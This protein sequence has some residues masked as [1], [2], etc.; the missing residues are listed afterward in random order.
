MIQNSAMI[1]AVALF[2]CVAGACSPAHGRIV[3]S[4]PIELPDTVPLRDPARPAISPVGIGTA[5]RPARA[6]R[7]ERAAIVTDQLRRAGGGSF[8]W[9]IF[10]PP[11]AL[12]WGGLGGGQNVTNQGGRPA[13]SS[14]S[15]PAPTSTSNGPRPVSTVIQLPRPIRVPGL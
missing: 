11:G 2:A 13:P 4:R 15:T 14:V 10:R 1:R 5:E 12:T 7:P 6:E 9:V 8:G 3:V